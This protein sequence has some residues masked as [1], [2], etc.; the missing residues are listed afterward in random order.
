[1]WSIRLFVFL[2][3]YF[4]WILK[5]KEKPTQ[6]FFYLEKSNIL[7]FSI[8]QKVYNK[9]WK[10]RKT[11]NRK[12]E[13]KLL[14][15][16]SW[17]NKHPLSDVKYHSSMSKSAANQVESSGVRFPEHW[18]AEVFERSI[19]FGLGQVLKIA[20]YLHSCSLTRE[21]LSNKKF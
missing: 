2:I 10:N 17:K 13:S 18:H 8:Q 5:S 1:M 9:S 4:Y 12:S 11:N 15:T 19:N 21:S 20:C 14:S 7:V 6:Y 16:K 3:F